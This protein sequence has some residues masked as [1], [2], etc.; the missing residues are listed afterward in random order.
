MVNLAVSGY[1]QSP[2]SIVGSDQV[3]FGGVEVFQKAE[4]KVTIQAEKPFKVKSVDGQGDGVSVPLLPVAANKVQV[5]TVIFSP[6]KPGPVKKVLTL[7]TDTGKSVT[8][9]V[10]GIGKDP[11]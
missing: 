4:R 9:S 1:V 8:L 11:Q 3:K 6:D 2:L 5:V 7:K 10:E